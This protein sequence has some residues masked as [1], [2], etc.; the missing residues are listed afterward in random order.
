MGGALQ[1]QKHALLLSSVQA[2][3]PPVGYAPGHNR[4]PALL[5]RLTAAASALPVC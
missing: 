1:N 3:M 4:V 2:G 5:L